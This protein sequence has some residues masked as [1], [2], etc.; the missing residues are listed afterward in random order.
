MR[1]LVISGGGSKG[2]FAV[3][4]LKYLIG[5]KAHQYDYIAGTSTGALIAPLAATREIDKL[6]EIYTTRETKDILKKRELFDIG[7][8]ITKG[9]TLEDFDSF[10]DVAPLREFA[11]QI[12]FPRYDAIM[13]SNITV[14]FSAICLQDAEITYFSTK[15]INNNSKFEAVLIENKEQML[16]AIM[17][18]ANQPVLMPPV[19]F[20]KRLPT[21]QYVDGGVRE[22]APIQGVIANNVDEIDVI[23]HSPPLMPFTPGRFDNIIDILKQTISIFSE[24]VAVN[25]LDVAILLAKENGI[26]INVYRPKRELPIKDSL[27]FNPLVMRD[28]LNTGYNIAEEIYPSGA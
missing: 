2:A 9:I 1:G 13:S 11:K 15:P 6:E 25:D 27:V 3:G 20:T 12:L 10:F 23:L 16:N 21:R 19:E 5:I 14:M 18:S 7:R 4:V 24:D 22:Y 26:K 28:V 8:L 17:A